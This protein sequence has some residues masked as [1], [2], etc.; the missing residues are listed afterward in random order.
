MSSKPEIITDII[1]GMLDVSDPRH[2]VLS[3]QKLGDLFADI[4]KHDQLVKKVFINYETYEYLLSRRVL[5]YEATIEEIGQTGCVGILWNAR[6]F[7]TGMTDVWIV[8]EVGDD[9]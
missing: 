8:R 4:E 2:G 6:V 3:A 5:L 1:S 9:G 7:V